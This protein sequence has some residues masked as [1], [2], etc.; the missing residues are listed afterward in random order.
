MIDWK[1]FAILQAANGRP[2]LRF[3]DLQRVVRNPRTLA[4]KLRKMEAEG[5]VA[6]ENGL[7]S[8]TPSGAE[9]AKILEGYQRLVGGGLDIK[10]LERVPHAA[11]L[12]LLRDYCE[13][14][15][16]SYKDRLEGVV[17]FG[18]VARGD[19]RKESDIDLLV[20]VEGWGNLRE[21]ERIEELSP[22]K[23]KLAN[24]DSHAGAI[25]VGFYPAIH[26]L[27]LDPAELKSFR[28]LYLDISADG[29]IL[30]DRKGAMRQFAD[31]VRDW[32]ERAGTNRIVRPDGSFYWILAPIRLGEVVELGQQP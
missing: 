2:S 18:S 8:L 32:A 29:I 31:S 5:L 26:V 24:C 19:W 27:P 12:P 22:F 17:L 16:G 28:P 25:R 23:S 11:Y 20:V 9:A 10:N 3:S 4:L 21:W 6:K 30:F 15:W 7:Y 14:L 1:A 13:L